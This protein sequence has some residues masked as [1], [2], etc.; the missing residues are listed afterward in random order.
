MRAYCI[1]AYI[2]SIKQLAT[3]GRIN[4]IDGWTFN[5]ICK[6]DT[7]PTI[8]IITYF[9]WK[10]LYKYCA[11]L[12]IRGIIAYAMKIIQS[13][14]PIRWTHVHTHYKCMYVCPF[15][16]ISIQLRACIKVQL[17][18]KR[19][20]VQIVSEIWTATLFYPMQ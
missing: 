14:I 1:C 16:C 7:R 4:K 10:L 11:P 19:L 3:I 20:N 17:Y 18:S 9:Y 15:V 5:N 2:S 8:K 13:T 12:N 6:E